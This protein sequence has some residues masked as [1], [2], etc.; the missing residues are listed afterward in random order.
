MP[1]LHCQLP[2]MATQVTNGVIVKMMFLL[3]FF[4][5]QSIIVEATES[6]AV[7]VE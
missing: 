1:P 6:P 5:L 2:I 7:P 3:L 4:Y